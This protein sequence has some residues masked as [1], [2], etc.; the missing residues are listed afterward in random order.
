MQKFSLNKTF[1]NF[2]S[3]FLNDHDEEYI[4]CNQNNPKCLNSD[5]T[6]VEIENVIKNLPRGKTAGIDGLV[7]EMFMSSLNFITPHLHAL[8]NKVLHMQCY[9]DMWSEA[10]ISPLF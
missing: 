4:D 2:V 8:F 7:Y 3:N 1:D 10:V 5:I 6:I 9:P